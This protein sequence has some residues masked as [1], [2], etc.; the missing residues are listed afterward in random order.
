M[1]IKK[2]LFPLFLIFLILESGLAQSRLIDTSL[3]HITL[4]VSDLNKATKTYSDLGF[5]P[6]DGSLHKNGL[7]NKH[8]KFK[9]GSSLELMTV[10]GNPSDAKAK[11]Y[12]DFLNEKEGAIYL[13]LKAPFD[14]VMKYA[15]SLY[16]S[17]SVIDEDL[18]SY[19]TF[20]NK[21]VSSFYFIGY[22]N[23]ISDPDYATTHSNKVTGIKAVWITASPMFK[24]LI[25]ALGAD[26]RGTLRTPDNKENVVYRLNGY[27]FIIDDS[28]QEDSK[29]MGIQFDSSDIFSLEW[30][31]P[32]EN[33]GVW[34]TFR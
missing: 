22:T 6:K 26:F 10:Q 8:L 1:P 33:H 15:D 5:T 3:D 16:L 18:F 24:E 23:P 25:I 32:S 14:K 13:A 7:L 34:I 20:E 21:G 2:I 9:D 17:Y 29:I 27:D 28:T 19:I 12:Q 30:L 31:P 4:A 11:A